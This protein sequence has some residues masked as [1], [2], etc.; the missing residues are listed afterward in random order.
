MSTVDDFTLQQTLGSG[1]S[2]KVKLALDSKGSQYALKI[3]D[4]NNPQNSKKAMTLLKKEVEATQKLNH[5]NIVKYHAF[6]EVAE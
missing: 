1:F 4:L 5:P 2:A 6:K 3:F